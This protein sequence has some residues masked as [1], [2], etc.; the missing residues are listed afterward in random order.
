[1]ANKEKLIEKAQKQIQK[2]NLEK[3][4]VEYQN[5]SK[6][7]SKDVS[8][9]LRIGDLYVK[10][11]KVAEAIK[12]YSDVARSN[13]QQGFYLKSIAVYKQV[14]KLDELNLDV[15]YRLAELYTKQRLIADA[16]GEYSV[17]VASFD[18]KGKSNEALELLR[19]MVEIDAENIGVRLKLAE[20]LQRQKFDV[21][22]VAEFATILEMLLAKD[23]LDRAETIYVD[24]YNSYPGNV[25]I[26][27]GLSEIFKRKGEDQQY[28]RF[29]KAL[30]NAHVESGDKVRAREVSEA[31]L[32]KS[33][34]DEDALAFLGL[35]SAPAVE[36]APSTEDL[37]VAES[38][39]DES[40]SAEVETG[41]AEIGEP[42]EGI[43]EEPEE[44]IEIDVDDFNLEEEPVV[45]EAVSEAPSDGE[46]AS[47]QEPEVEFDIP[48]EPTES[49]EEEQS[50]EL[51]GSSGEVVE[52]ET[53]P[54][55]EPVIEEVEEAEP[56][57]VIE[58][59]EE[60]DPVATETDE[61]VEQ[62]VELNTAADEVEAPEAE[63]EVEPEVELEPEV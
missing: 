36:E 1:M 35:D 28:L 12:E 49:T 17:I 15:H 51:L 29:A 13:S 31:I 60:L 6:L 30:K 22:A 39:A 21:D 24:L 9:R 45:D 2:G 41:D 19:K 43:E 55:P 37:S 56:E 44:E 47:E 27:E 11:G 34:E 53:E 8:I 50:V 40:V 4:I 59:V 32:E 14:L 57:P 52:D 46:E 38:V 23:K 33:P 54:E 7:D 48:D 62:E 20:N 16:I 3:A 63:T 5:A 18:K 25:S 26:L 42:E 10:T 61:P 58:E